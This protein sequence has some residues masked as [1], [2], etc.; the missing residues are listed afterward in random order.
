MPAARAASSRLIPSEALASASSRLLTRPS[1]SRRA[2][3]R[4]SAGVRPVAIGTA[5]MAQAPGLLSLPGQLAA[6]RR[7]SSLPVAGMTRTI[8]T[9]AL[10]AAACPA[11]ADEAVRA[12]PAQ[13]VMRPLGGERVLAYYVPS[14]G[15]CDTV[16][17]PGEELGPR[18]RVSLA[19]AEAATV[20]DAGGG[21][22]VL[23]CGPAGAWM[24]V[25]RHAPT[26]ETASAE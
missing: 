2:I 11:L 5:T 17:M 19:P 6:R 15:R 3:A 1:R 9:L 26:Q 23:T 13:A 20:E 18:L 4:S 7:R 8:L 21:S 16:G 22:L 14:A 24:T 25:E 10:L 12:G